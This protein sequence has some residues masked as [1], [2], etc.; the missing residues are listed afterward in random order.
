MSGILIGVARKLNA[1]EAPLKNPC[2]RTISARRGVRGVR[3]WCARVHALAGPPL[4]KG[5]SS[6]RVRSGPSA[7]AIVES[8]RI[9][10]RR[11]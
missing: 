8:L 9:E 5:I 4:R 2:S 3:R 11:S 1:A 7:T 6:F 10:L